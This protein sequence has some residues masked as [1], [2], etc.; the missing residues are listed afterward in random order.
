MGANRWCSAP[1]CFGW[2]GKWKPH[3]HD[4]T[5]ACDADYSSPPLPTISPS[6]HWWTSQTR[7]PLARGRTLRIRT[8]GGL[9][10][11]MTKFATAHPDDTILPN[12]AAA[13]V[14]MAETIH[15]PPIPSS[16]I[17]LHQLLAM[18]GSGQ[19]QNGSEY[20]P[21]KR[22][23]TR[24][25]NGEGGDG[26]PHLNSAKKCWRHSSNKRTNPNEQTQPIHS[27]Q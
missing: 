23:A 1:S 26:V 2:I 9:C 5:L 10:T 11:R 14:Q 27:D 21:K 7:T 17:N 15:L 16:S 6:R 12:T 3:A 4:G 13:T 22:P 24:F 20:S 8:C 18:D 25:F 19:D